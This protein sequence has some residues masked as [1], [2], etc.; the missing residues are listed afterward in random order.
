LAEFDYYITDK[1]ALKPYI[2]V[3]LGYMNY[4]STD[5]DESGLVYGG[6]AGVQF[7][8][9]DNI[10]MDLSYRYSASQIDEVDHTGSF[11]F[12]LNYIF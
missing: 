12:G 3:N 1:Y 11:T 8:A 9:N 2:G 10:E 6:Q 7:R 5:I 4:E